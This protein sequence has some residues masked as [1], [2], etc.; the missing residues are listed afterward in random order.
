MPDLDLVIVG[1]GA[2]GTGAALEARRRGLA[3]R[4][5]EAKARTGG[6][7]CTDATSLSRPFDL[8]CHW[9]HSASV[10]PLRELADELGVAYAPDAPKLFH[11]GCTFLDARA[12]EEGLAA[13]A[14]FAAA[15]RRCDEAAGERSVAGAC[16]RASPW[17]PY[18]A[19]WMEHE[20]AAS[21]EEISTADW[22]AQRN[23]G[24]DRPV[25]GGYGE[26]VR[27]V[28]DG[29][30][31]ELGAPVRALDCAGPLV[32]VE[33]ERGTLRARAVLLTVS[34][35]VLAAEAIALR[36]HPWPAWKQRAIEGL[37][38]GSST[39]V[40]LEVDA[41]A[42]DPALRNRFVHCLAEAPANVSWHLAPHGFEMAV[43]YLGGR[44]SRELARAGEAAQ[45]DFAATH[46][47]TLLG[48]DVKRHLGRGRA[49]PFD[50]DPW[51]GGGYSYGRF[52]YGN[53][54]AALAEPVD[55]R[56]HFAGEAC[57][58]EFPASA[59]GAFRS[60]IDAVARIG[61]GAAASR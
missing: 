3:F 58:V 23:T 13:W 39:K 35:A 28:L 52:G 25:P 40:A 59:D 22:A 30:P 9:L 34:T 24:E 29:I 27:R 45:I 14:S 31:V 44:S 54:R 10:N 41:A 60:G 20:A 37:P 16:D 21:L 1:S 36:P 53:Q 2:A 47:A 17:Y 43:A 33:T 50:L 42:I 48:Q 49:T 57:S 8:G 5:L 26:L 56:I 46:L 38:L 11:D 7:A 61:R 6:R 51:L 15:G 19:Q 18:F 4:V 32:A 12:V 55:E